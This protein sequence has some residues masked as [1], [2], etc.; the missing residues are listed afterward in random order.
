VKPGPVGVGSPISVLPGAED[1]T[2]LA[3][4]SF[5]RSDRA[6]DMRPEH[7][8][9]LFIQDTR[10]VSLWTLTV[11]GTPLDALSA[12][13][14]EPYAATFVAR[15][16]HSIETAEPTLVVKRHRLIGD[17]LREQVV[18]ENFGG[19]TAQVRLQ[20]DVGADFADLFD[21]KEG[22][23]T[24]IGPVRASI[25][26][27]GLELSIR[28]RNRRRCVLIHAADA[29]TTDDSLAWQV[30]IEPQRTWSASVDVR[31][32]EPHI[33]DPT[34]TGPLVGDTTTA[35]QRMH[36]WRL[37]APVVDCEN[38]Q[39]QSM[40]ERTSE[41]LGALRITDNERPES[42]VVAAGAPWFMA[43]FGRDSLLTSLFALPWD[44][45]LAK[46]TLNTLARLQGTKI[47]ALSEEE[48][49]RILHEVRW[50]IDPARAL[51]ASPIYYGSVDATPLF[52]ILLGE[53][54]RWGMAQ[55]DVLTLLPAADRALAWV[56]EFGD[57]DGDGFVEYERK[58]ELGLLNQGWKD[59][60]DALKFA[61]GQSA[62][63]PIALAE[64]QGYVYAAYR[65]RSSL[66]VLTGDS[67]GM[68]HWLAKAEELRDQFNDA[69]WLPDHQYYALALDG[70]K[71]PVDALASNQG[72]CL[73]TGIVAED[74]ADM[75]VDHLVSPDMFS[76][77]GV[78]TLA[79]GMAAYN[80]VSYH[81]GSVW[82]HDNALLIGGLARYQRY[83]AAQRVAQGLL[84][85]VSYF[86]ARPPEL[87]CGFDRRGL[88]FPVPYP[89]SCSPQAW[90][91]A[92]PIAIVTT[93]LGIDPQQ[94]VVD[95]HLPAVW[96]RVQLA[97]LHLNGRRFT[98]DSAGPSLV[99][100]G[101]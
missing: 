100:Q 11:N 12:A 27:E 79:R 41:D 85:A 37:A 82:P 26:D 76:G 50:G 1:V 46:G 71:R 36:D 40:L 66:A 78:R 29:T 88:S 92:A 31:V 2:V 8:N 21:V 42:D 99:E 39:L 64:V 56:S 57:A 77:W 93:L 94:E 23:Q 74:R 28:H 33:H 22:R 60:L 25:G 89:T 53:A 69:F 95:P 83:E 51:G 34:A 17:Q 7:A 80:P 43:L 14:V 58:T 98:V 15:V 62:Q 87:F 52:V 97:G 20:L 73:W 61:N 35:A 30:S 63:G 67:V 13:V 55:E 6:G 84:E 70:R 68:R 65:A 86:G 4:S 18:L 5:C 44:P 38:P 101:A 54:A 91:A 48:P 32:T 24:E 16:H 72:H 49:G 81:N 19:E 3:G 10:V 45:R 75:V 96:G 90:A 47:D 9:G 59:S